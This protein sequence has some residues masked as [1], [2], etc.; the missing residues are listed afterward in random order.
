[1]FSNNAGSIGQ[2]QLKKGLKAKNATTV[3]IKD[4]TSATAEKATRLSSASKVL[5]DEP[6]TVR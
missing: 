5:D 3:L 4:T 2:S 6:G 1:M